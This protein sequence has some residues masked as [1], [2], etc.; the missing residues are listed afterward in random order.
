MLSAGCLALTALLLDLEVG[1]DLPGSEDVTLRQAPSTT[2]LSAIFVPGTRGCEF[3]LER[4]GQKPPSM[5]NGR[6]LALLHF[7]QDLGYTHTHL[8]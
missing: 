8:A 6:A 5:V 2:V 4:E 1:H 7:C 3:S